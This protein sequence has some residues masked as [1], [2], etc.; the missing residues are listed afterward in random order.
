MKRNIHK[1]ATRTALVLLASLALPMAVFA[2]AGK[3]ASTVRALPDIDNSTE[4][5][6]SK[7]QSEKEQQ[8]VTEAAEALS[9]IH[10]ALDAL[11]KNDGKKAF[12]ALQTASEKLDTVLAKHPYLKLI[13][14]DVVVNT[15]DFTGDAKTIEKAVS[16]AEDLLGDGKVQ[17]ARQMLGGLASEISISTLNMPLGSFPA[18]VKKAMAMA[19][20][21]ENKAALDFLNDA[22]NMLVETTDILPL[23]FIRAE[24][25]VNRASDLEH[26][27]D[28]AKEKNREEILKLADAAKEQLKIAELLGYGDKNDFKPVY[29]EIDDIKEDV[30]TEKSTAAWENIKRK[31]AG[32]KNKIS[33]FQK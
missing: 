5:T 16:E 6:R 10:Q 32:L 24:A 19:N 3:Q 13:P 18:A 4:T 11:N 23:P 25:L 27:K 22:L 33:P 20:N 31:L 29:T 8:I 9:N 14:T 15:I 30:H 26:K 21:G 2:D 12:Y 17:A 1:R 7:I 28:V